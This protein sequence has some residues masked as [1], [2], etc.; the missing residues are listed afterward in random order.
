MKI[1]PAPL[2]VLAASDKPIPRFIA[3]TG[4]SNRPL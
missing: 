3:V 1:I 4:G 2:L